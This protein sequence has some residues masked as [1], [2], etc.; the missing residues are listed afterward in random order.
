LQVARER[1]H[2]EVRPPAP[3]SRTPR[4]SVESTRADGAEAIGAGSARCDLRGL[5]VEEVDDRLVEALDRVAAAGG[6]SLTV[7]H[8]LGSGAL[9]SAVRRHLRE[10]PYIDEFAPAPDDQGGDGVTIAKMR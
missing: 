6:S 7:V 3:S 4:I 5:R 1:V 9:R 10:S 2:P 8:G